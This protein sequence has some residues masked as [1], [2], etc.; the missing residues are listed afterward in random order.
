MTL[1]LEN[2]V[3]RPHVRHVDPLTVDVVAIGVP[4][5][6]GDALVAHVIAGEALLEAYGKQQDQWSHTIAGTVNMQIFKR[7]MERW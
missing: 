6:H 1:H 4:A 5:A 2:I 7:Q 3:S